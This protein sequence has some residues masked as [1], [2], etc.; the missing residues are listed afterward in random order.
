M[1]QAL[2]RAQILFH[3]GFGCMLLSG[4]MARAE[5]DHIILCVLLLLAGAV[6]MIWGW[7]YGKLRCVCPR[8]GCSLYESGVR[9]PSRLPNFCPRCGQ[10]L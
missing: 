5:V 7:T 1:G 6:L 2:K 3:S 10:E 9:M 8:C 4:L